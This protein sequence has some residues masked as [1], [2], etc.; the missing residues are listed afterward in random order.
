MSLP[1]P[2]LY[3]LL[4]AVIVVAVLTTL[5]IVWRGVGIYRIRRAGPRPLRAQQHRLWRDP[6]AEAPLDLAAGPGG[7]DGV[8]APPFTFL[9]EHGT[10]SQPC[11]SIRDGRGRRWR[12]KWGHEVNAETFAVRLAFGCG[13]FAEVTHFVRDGTIRNVPALG[14]ASACIHPDSGGF[15]DARFELDDPAVNKLFE[16]HSWSWNDNPFVGTREL[17]GLK[18]LV[19]LL[20]NWDTKDRRSRPTLRRPRC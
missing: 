17:N 8:P 3:G 11:V 13:Y 10:G 12:V 18:I 15:I 6:R 7:R 4:T 5:Q 19:M 2:I 14:R 16:E 1:A 20:S 9:E